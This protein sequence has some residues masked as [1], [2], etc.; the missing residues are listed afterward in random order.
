MSGGGEPS[1]APG[2]GSSPEGHLLQV[3]VHLVSS[4]SVCVGAL[5]HGRREE[6]GGAGCWEEVGILLRLQD[7]HIQRLLETENPI[8]IN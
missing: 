1:T 3:G 4:S 6:R 5:L 8:S 2:H 7:G